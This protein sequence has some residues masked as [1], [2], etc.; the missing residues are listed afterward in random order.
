MEGKFPLTLKMDGGR[1]TFQV[2]A[3]D[4][5]GNLRPLDYAI[6]LEP[7]NRVRVT[8]LTPGSLSSQSAGDVQDF[9][10]ANG[11]ALEPAFDVDLT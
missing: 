8:R 7:N 1:G 9:A 6:E 5:Q 3:F 2:Q 11:P 4:A 10:L